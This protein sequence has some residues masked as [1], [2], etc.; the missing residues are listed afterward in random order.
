MERIT[1]KLTVSNETIYSY[2]SVDNPECFMQNAVLV[3]D[4]KDTPL[5]NTR[6]EL[7]NIDAKSGNF[8]VQTQ[9]RNNETINFFIRG[10]TFGNKIAYKPITIEWKAPYNGPPSFPSKIPSI[11]LKINKDEQLAGLP[12]F[13]YTS[14][15]AIDAE[16]D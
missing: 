2:F 14:P 12:V 15:I 10:K 3:Q 8:T 7:V 9:S 4:V 5:N 16:G 6:A 13:K 11:T 1:P